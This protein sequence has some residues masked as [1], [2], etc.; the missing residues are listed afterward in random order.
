[1][2]YKRNIGHPKIFAQRGVKRY[3][4]AIQEKGQFITWPYAYH[5]GFNTGDN[6]A[7]GDTVNEYFNI[8]K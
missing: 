2:Y 3:S 4:V 7:E 1:M 5:S 6:L 8:I